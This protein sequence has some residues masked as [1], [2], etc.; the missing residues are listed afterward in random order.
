MN[1]YQK[2]LT[3]F[4]LLNL[5]FVSIGLPANEDSQNS[6]FLDKI[7]SIDYSPLGRRIAGGEAVYVNTFYWLNADGTIGKTDRGWSRVPKDRRHLV[8]L[9]RSEAQDVI[10]E[11]LNFSTCELPFSKE[12]IPQTGPEKDVEYKGKLI[13]GYVHVFFPNGQLQ[14]KGQRLNQA[15]EPD[16]NGKANGEWIYYDENCRL[17]SKTSWKEG[18]AQYRTWFNADGSISK[19]GGWDANGQAG[20]WEYFDESGNLSRKGTWKDNKQHGVWEYYNANGS[21]KETIEWDMGEN[22]TEKK[23]KQSANIVSS[24]SMIPFVEACRDAYM[25]KR[26]DAKLLLDEINSEVRKAINNNQVSKDVVNNSI[27]KQQRLV[28]MMGGFGYEQKEMCDLYTVM[29]AQLKTPTDR[30]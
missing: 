10:D 19:K 16:I 8:F 13:D 5:S 30:F 14:R 25:M 17:H 1:I 11:A 21:L 12:G 2:T 3:L 22:A 20:M 29:A 6:K 4:L 28:D 7:S 15:G 18:S 23:R 26:G 9:K 24:A 27:N